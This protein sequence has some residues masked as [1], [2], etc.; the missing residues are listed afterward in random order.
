MKNII[1][2]II[3][4]WNINFEKKTRVHQYGAIVPCVE[5]QMSAHEQVL[6]IV[7]YMK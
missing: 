5:G 3:R 6:D 7:N 4:S 1:K 2:N